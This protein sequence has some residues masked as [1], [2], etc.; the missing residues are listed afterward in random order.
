MKKKV[1]GF[2]L[3]VVVTL[4]PMHAKAAEFNGSVFGS[5]DENMASTTLNGGSIVC[6]KDTTGDYAT[7]YMGI[8]VTSGSTTGFTVKAILTNMTFYE[9]EE[10]NGW[11]MNSPTT[12][13]NNI[14]LSFSSK[15][16]IS[17]VQKQLVAKITYKVNNKSQP[18]SIQISA[19]SNNDETPTYPSCG[20]QGGKYYC[21]NQ[22]ECT[23]AQYDKECLPENPKTGSA[24][25]YIVVL[26]GL[27]V[28][29]A[30]YFVTR[31]K[32]KLYHV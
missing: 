28:A 4:L 13:G 7:C 27:G 26:G 14:T 30:L 31:K 2:M 16:G 5:A 3:A 22:Q 6:P 24:I 12:S 17:A 19:A 20:T 23:K 25:P 11:T 21:K 9:Y 8:N 29:G 32:A 18:C 15:T 10:L 1:F